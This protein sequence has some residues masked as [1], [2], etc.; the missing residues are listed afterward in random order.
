MP[1]VPSLRIIARGSRLPAGESSVFGSSPAGAVIA[2]AAGVDEYARRLEAACMDR[3]DQHAGRMNTAVAK[4]RLAR[5][6]PSLVAERFTRQIDHRV[7]IVH[8][9]RQGRGGVIVRASIRRPSHPSDSRHTRAGFVPWLARRKAA[10][11][12]PHVMPLLRVNLRQR[13]PQKPGAAGDDDLHAEIG[14]ICAE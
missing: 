8:D 12:D 6:R 13:T 5:C 9:C 14:R 2:G 10:G 3:R 11:E 1:R 4:L 7:R